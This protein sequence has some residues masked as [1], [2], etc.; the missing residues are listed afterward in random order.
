MEEWIPSTRNQEV[1][2]A[3]QG[4]VDVKFMFHVD[5][6]PREV[7]GGLMKKS[8]EG[9]GVVSV[10]RHFVKK[11]M[12]KGVEEWWKEDGKVLEEFVVDGKEGRRGGWRVDQGFGAEGEKGQGE[13]SEVCEFVVFGAWAKVEDHTVEFVKTK[14][15][16]RYSKI[17]EFLDGAEIRHAQVIDFV[18]A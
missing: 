2:K 12:R 9:G 5:L 6:D 1:L 4:E 13:D 17:K 16:Q 15:S 10:G 14:Q 18:D 7:V 3:M 8:Q 11:G